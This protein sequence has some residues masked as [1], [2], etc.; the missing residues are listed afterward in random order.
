M[1]NIAPQSAAKKHTYR[2][3]KQHTRNLIRSW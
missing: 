1:Q 2:K 3:K